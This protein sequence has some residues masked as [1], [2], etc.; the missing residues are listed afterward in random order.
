MKNRFLVAIAA[1]LGL[2]LVG[3]ADSDGDGLSDS[4]E[5]KIGSDPD[6]V[7][8]DGDLIYDG[9]EYDNGLDPTNPDS[10][11]DGYR[12]GDEL[13]EG[14]DPLDASD[15]IYTGGWPYN[16]DKRDLGEP[17]M[18]GQAQVG[19]F[20]PFYRA[21]DQFGD[22]VDLYDFAAEGKPLII[23][24]SA[25]W[26]G[27]CNQMAAWLEGEDNG[28]F[29]ASAN[30]LREAVWN[31]DVYWITAIYEDA[32]GNPANEQVA[33]DWYESYPTAEVPVLADEDGDMASFINPPGIPS[34]SMLDDNFE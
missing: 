2:L 7:D 4:I 24:I 19:Q 11:G 34:L 33:A 20:M 29:N 14:S 5:K 30:P 1:A 9:D 15:K 13:V 26:C 6:N 32:F 28:F 23:D 3:C 25:V 8:T 31:G 22:R 10:D 16:P 17:D 27:P 12:D 21:K 18:T